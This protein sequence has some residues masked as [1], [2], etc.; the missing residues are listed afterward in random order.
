MGAENV[1]YYGTGFL[2][3]IFLLAYG[4]WLDNMIP[5][6]CRSSSLRIGVRGIIVTGAV[7]AVLC[8]STMMCAE[9]CE[10]H[11]EGLHNG[12]LFIVGGGFTT[13]MV[14]SIMAASAVQKATLSDGTTRC[15][16]KSTRDG[17]ST[18]M[19]LIGFMA[20]FYGIGSIILSIVRVY[21]GDAPRRHEKATRTAGVELTSLR[22][23][24]AKEAK[25]RK[26]KKEADA[27]R[28]EVNDAREEAEELE[29]ERKRQDEKEKAD[30]T[31]DKAILER[32]KKSQETATKQLKQG[33][34]NQQEHAVAELIKKQN[35]L[36]DEGRWDD[37]NELESAI[38]AEEKKLT[39]LQKPERRLNANTS[40]W[41]GNN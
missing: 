25:T 30:K 10:G 36:K 5:G 32:R 14:F 41:W 15:L 22:K 37:A 23:S 21:R 19:S 3:S 24:Q 26:L 34:I 33:K 7:L 16:T 6:N 18:W 13:G 28:Q 38:T 2:F 27:K 17:V 11:E 9:F 40:P 39:E 29:K 8:L 35:K 20:G 12:M 1:F 4:A 31:S